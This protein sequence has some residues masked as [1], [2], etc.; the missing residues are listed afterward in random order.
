MTVPAPLEL[1]QARVL[2]EWIDYN[3]HMNVAWYVLAFDL[4]TDAFLDYIGLTASWRDEHQ[5]STF[6]GAMHVNYLGELREGDPIRITTQ[7]LG[8][9]DK[10]IHYFHHMY[11]AGS[12]TLAATNELLSLY[13]DMRTRRVAPIPAALR[14]RLDSIVA[15]HR[16]LPRPE[17]AGH[18]IAIRPG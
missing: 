10:R 15:A 13:M 14:A 4:A 9:D 18:V 7:L 11:H 6:T 3:G 8:C 2:P 17:Q 12:G 5:A 1:Y 16:R